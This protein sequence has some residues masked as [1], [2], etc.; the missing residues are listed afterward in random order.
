MCIYWSRIHLHHDVNDKKVFSFKLNFFQL[1]LLFKML[2]FLRSIK[3][4]SIQMQVA[5]KIVYGNSAFQ[6]CSCI[7]FFTGTLEFLIRHAAHVNFDLYVP[8]HGNRKERFRIYYVTFTMETGHKRIFIPTHE[9]ELTLCLF[10][11]IPSLIEWSTVE[12]KKKAFIH[13]WA[14][15]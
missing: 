9:A 10:T 15:L 2:L 5:R 1:V 11:S 14:C 3:V 7:Y 6:K 12:L 13:Q 8:F 4:N